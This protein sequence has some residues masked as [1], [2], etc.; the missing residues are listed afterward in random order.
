MQIDINCDLGEGSGNDAHLMP[1]ISSCNI[2]CGGHYGDKETIRATIQLA[3]KHQVKIGAHPS[4]PDKEGFG[5]ASMALSPEEFTKTISE[6][7]SLF[8]DVATT[9]GVTVHHIKAH[10]ALYNDL[11]K[12]TLKV[13][14][15]LSSISPYKQQIKLFAPY[16]SVLRKVA[17]EQGFE[18][19]YEAFADRNYNED[20]SLVSRKNKQAL[21]ENPNEVATHV[22]NM[23]Q[24]GI[25]KTINGSQISIQAQTLCIHGDH[26]Y[27]VE[28]LKH[29]HKVFQKDKIT[30]V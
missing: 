5:R 18:I 2:A 26:V 20:L 17:S 4:Y 14:V 27:S 6:Q 11:V 12:D 22:L 24:N 7:L 21:I 8:F 16:E 19:C 28:I 15:F 13:K 25:V 9:E 1:L 23:I 30:I 10:G 3:K 29:I